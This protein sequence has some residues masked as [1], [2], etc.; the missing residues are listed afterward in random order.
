MHKNLPEPS[1]PLKAGSAISFQ[2]NH[3]IMKGICPFPGR[4]AMDN[5]QLFLFLL[6]ADR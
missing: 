2:L 1:V 6:M 3:K 5:F 4:I